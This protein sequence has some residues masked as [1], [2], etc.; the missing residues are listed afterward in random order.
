MY[1]G[2]AGRGLAGRREGAIGASAGGSDT[3]EGAVSWPLR[4]PGGSRLQAADRDGVPLVGRVK[5]NWCQARAL[6][7]KRVRLPKEAA[8]E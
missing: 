7:G 3:R 5:L 6:V 4:G 1:E 2:K 8:P